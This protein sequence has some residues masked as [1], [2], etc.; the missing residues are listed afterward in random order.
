MD[1]LKYISTPVGKTE[2]SPLITTIKLTRGRLV[3][4]W[5][6]FPS[7]PAG[8]LHLLLRVGIHQIYPFNT[9]ENLRLDDAVFPFTIGID[10]DEPP[11]LVDLATWNDSLAL[12]HALTISFSLEPISKKK[13]D[14]KTILRELISG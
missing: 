2:S 14:L 10:L 8:V 13:Y 5:V 3:G 4:G 1:F 12:A 7:G 9:G 6:Y 11:Y